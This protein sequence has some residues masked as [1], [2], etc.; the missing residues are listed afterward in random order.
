MKR[1]L[2]DLR[3]GNSFKKSDWKNRSNEYQFSHNGGVLKLLR[4]AKEALE[5]GVTD[6]MYEELDEAVAA[7]IKEVAERQKHLKIADKFGSKGW[8]VVDCYRADPLAENESD[9]KTVETNCGS[10]H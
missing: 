3:E 1:Q 5:E 4:R 9:E 2:E 6:E 8:C 7:G 10:G